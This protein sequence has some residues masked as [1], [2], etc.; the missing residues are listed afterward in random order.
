MAHALERTWSGWR[1]ERG[2]RGNV[3]R[4]FD[5]SYRVQRHWGAKVAFYLYLGGTGAGFV[6]VELW[7]RWWGI[8]DARTA[9]VGMWVG[10]ALAVLSALA[11][12]DHLGPVSRWSAYFTFRN[13]RRS[14]ISRGVTML[15]ALLALRLL[16]AL[17]SLPG[18]EGLP[19]AE[20]APLGD[21]L[22]VFVIALAIAFM[23]YTG[24]VISSWSAIAFWNTPLM[25][26]LFTSFSLLG[27]ITALMGVAWIDGGTAAAHTIF[28]FTSTWLVLLLATSSGLAALYVY[29][30]STA[31]RPARASVALLLRGPL[32]ARSIGGTVVLGLV[33]PALVFVPATFGVITC[34]TTTAPLFLGAIAATQVGGYFLRD[35]ILRAGVYGPPV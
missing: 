35:A 19:W 25:P 5:L 22:R 1:P 29:G 11:I 33:A 18:A 23:L 10:L 17:P 9:A 34:S 30:M 3:G 4:P 24:L 12:F 15:F 32:V 26:V 13:L 8:I 21:A 31:S 16:L 7:L 14:W 2:A 28:G 27:A 20:G 6:S